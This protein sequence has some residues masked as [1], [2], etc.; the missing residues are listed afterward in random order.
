M[1]AN[2][3]M[4]K[5]KFIARLTAIIF[6]LAIC[7]VG[8]YVGNYYYFDAQRAEIA[9]KTQEFTKLHDQNDADEL[10][11][12][13]LNNLTRQMAEAEEAYQ[14]LE[15]LVPSQAELPELLSDIE[16]SAIERNLKLNLF[17]Q[18]ALPQGQ[19]NSGA[20]TEVPLQIELVGYFDSINRYVQS[21]NRMRRILLVKE[22]RVGQ[23][24]SQVAGYTT[25]HALITCSAFVGEKIK[26]AQDRVAKN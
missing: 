18:S 25:S 24:P 3:E 16:H 22:I 23:E 8:Y 12:K 10:V 2:T 19:K 5:Q 13:N 20:L 9:A 14:S 17:Q 26:T 21:L 1:N 7:G 6:G 11:S 4:T 15:P